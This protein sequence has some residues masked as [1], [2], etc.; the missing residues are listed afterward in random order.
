V[1][2]GDTEAVQL[3]DALADSVAVS[4]TLPLPVTERV[5]VRLVVAERDDVGESLIPAPG[6][7]LLGT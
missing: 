6:R 7:W 4:V 1:A 5:A 3:I 2:V